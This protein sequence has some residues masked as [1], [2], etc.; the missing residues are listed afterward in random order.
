M[1][2]RFSVA[3]VSES[4]AQTF[5]LGVNIGRILKAGDFVA[6]QGELGAGKTVFVQGIAKGL[7]VPDAYAVV[8][9]TFTLINEYPGEAAPLY[10]LDVYRLSGSADLLDAGFDETVS[11]KGITVVEWAEKIAD[12]IPEAAIFLAFAYLAEAKREIRIS[13]EDES[14]MQRLKGVV[15]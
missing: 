12:F 2:N 1:E 5:E 11:R 6:L 3:L 10:H 14:V 4:P 8:S 15:F 9:P 7:G 13:V